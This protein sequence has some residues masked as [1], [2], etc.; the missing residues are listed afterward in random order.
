M[1]D[2]PLSVLLSAYQCGPGMGSV[3]QIGWEWYSRLAARVPV[4]L[5][6]HVRNRN[7]LEAAGAPLAGSEVHFVD[8]EW[9]AGPLWRTS[10]RLFPGSEHA[11]FL[12]SSLDFFAYDHAARAWARQRIA[13]G[14]RFHVVHQVTPVT[15]AAPTKLHTLGLPLVVGPLNAGLSTPKTFPE[16]MRE[17]SAWL[18]RLGNVGRS[19]DRFI[20]CSEAAAAIL[21]A[22]QAT[23]ASVPE[24]DRARC[25]PMI[26]NGVDLERFLP[27]PWPAPPSSSQPLRVVFVGRMIAS[28][29]VPML[30]DALDRVRRRV[31]VTATFIGDGPLRA[32]WEEQAARIGLVEAGVAT[33]AGAQ[34]LDAVA[35]AMR[36]AHVFCLPSVR[37]SGGAVL[38]EAMACCRPVIAVAHGGPAEI[39]DDGVGVLIPAD[40][41]GPVTEGLIDALLDV[42]E[43]PEPWRRRGL[44]GR[45]RVERLYSW[46]SKVEAG[47]RLYAELAGV[48][49]PARHEEPEL[50]GAGPERRR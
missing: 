20:G 25:R 35:R 16:L 7:A 39:V 1:S 12:L 21:V 23:L 33:F 28:K 2:A 46:A 47:L 36:E 32:A 22:T 18:M 38:L 45:H 5:L 15:N 42:A 41:P 29:G 50:V 30:L 6:T 8:T 24:R 31:P 19:F 37:E 44:E 13:E 14:T 49:V 27:S 4:T 17:E 10:R 9:L 43:H 11:T 3:S 40:G 48:P 26:E 34:P